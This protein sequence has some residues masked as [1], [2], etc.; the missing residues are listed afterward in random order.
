MIEVTTTAHGKPA[1]TSDQW[2]VVH[3]RW[4]SGAPGQFHRRIVS[5]HVDHDTA[6]IAAQEF[7]VKLMPEL[8]E[9]AEL[10]RDQ[11]IV[12]KP[13]YLTLLTSSKRVV[14]TR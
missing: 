9:R 13:K 7:G 1:L 2:Y 4:Q 8:V 10:E 3:S 14:P 5:E 12:H 11:V 6:R